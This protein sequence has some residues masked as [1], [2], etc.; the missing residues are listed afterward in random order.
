MTAHWGVAGL[1]ANG[2]HKIQRRDPAHVEG[3]LERANAFREAL[4]IEPP[5][6]SVYK[7]AY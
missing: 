6:R 2:N 7:L 3:T 1:V 4:Y 5:H